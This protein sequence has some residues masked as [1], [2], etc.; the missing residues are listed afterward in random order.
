MHSIRRTNLQQKKYGNIKTNI[1]SLFT[2]K[3][4]F[5]EHGNPGESR[6]TLTVFNVFNAL[7]RT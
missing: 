1:L 7:Q 2:L 5:T 6:L 4:R 3:A